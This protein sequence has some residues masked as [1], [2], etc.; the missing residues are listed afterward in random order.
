MKSIKLL[1]FFSYWCIIGFTNAQVKD[2]VY[3]Q[4]LLDSGYVF[5]R[6]APDKAI[7]IYKKSLQISNE[8]NYDKGAFRSLLYTGIVFSDNGKYDEAITAYKEALPF[9]K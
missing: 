3:V 8:I 7:K 6:S 4:R 2:S 1:I 5:E 9:T